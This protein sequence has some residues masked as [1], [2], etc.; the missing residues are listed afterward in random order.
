MKLYNVDQ[1]PVLDNNIEH[2]LTDLH[3]RLGR[4]IEDAVRNGEAIK[5][6]DVCC[7]IEEEVAYIFPRDVINERA[8][9]NYAI[10]LDI[11]NKSAFSVVNMTF[12]TGIGVSIYE[13]V[14]QAVRE[15]IAGRAVKTLLKNSNQKNLK[16]YIKWVKGR[17]WE[18]TFR[19]VGPRI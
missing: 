2:Y 1:K 3:V 16:K 12:E 6:Q 18:E 5:S 8:V 9:F 13:L 17:V 19:D 15:E 14:A 10:Q 7:V 11:L 4:G